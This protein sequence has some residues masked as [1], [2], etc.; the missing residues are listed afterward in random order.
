MNDKYFETQPGNIN[1][2][3]K[4]G[5]EMSR[6]KNIDN[7]QTETGK[8]TTRREALM[9]RR[10]DSEKF[11]K[12]AERRANG[13]KAAKRDKIRS[14]R[15]NAREEMRQAAKEK[16]RV[17]GGR[18][19]AVHEHY[20]NVRRNIHADDLKGAMK[21]LKVAIDLDPGNIDLLIEKANLLQKMRQYGA[22]L[23]AYDRTHNLVLNRANT[24][25]AD[26][27]HWLTTI[28]FHRA[29]TLEAMGRKDDAFD[30]HSELVRLVEANGRN[31]NAYYGRSLIARCRFLLKADRVLTA[32]DDSRKILDGMAKGT[33]ARSSEAWLVYGV[34]LELKEKSTIGVHRNN[35]EAIKS[36]E[37]AI[38]LDPNCVQARSCLG[39]TLIQIGQNSLA[40]MQFEKILEIDPDNA[41]A[42]SS[43]GQLFFNS[44]RHDDA[45]RMCKRAIELN[46]DG[47]RDPETF[48]VH[49]FVDPRRI[50][51]FIHLGRENRSKNIA[52]YRRIAGLDPDAQIPDNGDDAGMDGKL[53]D[54]IV[55]CNME[56]NLDPMN[57]AA[58]SGLGDAQV[59]K[60]E[61]EKASETYRAASDMDPDNIV[62]LNKLAM[63]AVFRERRDEA[64]EYCSK[65][66]LLDSEDK[67]AEALMSEVKKQVK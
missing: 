31:F 27:Y 35:S 60:G 61:L 37:R 41:D 15:N 42:M 66:L 53:S 7:R 59:G 19:E 48:Y 5:R 57:V 44:R 20:Q 29:E 2:R 30:C 21:E 28:L 17:E 67:N 24:G 36:Y 47:E 64:V 43:L 14:D 10:A 25:R 9:M 18:M 32:F 51:S 8:P 12:R 13:E 22:A 1:T 11:L 23:M 3:N 33:I 38:V 39:S 50:L 26:I 49:G 34:A 52:S 56:I 55:R 45:E 16:R 65:A 4:G 46:P 54:D 6:D 40:I 58:Y 63:V 62:L